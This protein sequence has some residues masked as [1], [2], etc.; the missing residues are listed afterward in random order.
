M[1][2]IVL[3]ASGLSV[4]DCPP[5]TGKSGRLDRRKKKVS[6]TPDPTN[7]VQVIVIIATSNR[8]SRLKPKCQDI[9]VKLAMASSA[10]P[11]D[12]HL[13]AR[14][15]RLARPKATPTKRNAALS[16]T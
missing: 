14:S 16:I 11:I 8:Y 7:V 12:V 3:L 6:S 13:I 9:K 15:R 5:E 1:P 10:A 2:R 4:A